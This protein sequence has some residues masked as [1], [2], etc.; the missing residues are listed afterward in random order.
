ML[1]R[2]VGDPEAK[3]TEYQ[4]F[5]EENKV[6]DLS[7]FI[8]EIEYRWKGSPWLGGYNSTLE[9]ILQNQL[10]HLLKNL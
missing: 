4:I 6:T 8:N 2:S 3:N 5:A 10:M 9:R 1:Q 7:S